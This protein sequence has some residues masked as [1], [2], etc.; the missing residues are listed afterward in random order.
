M[1]NQHM[2]VSIYHW[3]PHSGQNSFDV[4]RKQNQNPNYVVIIVVVVVVVVKD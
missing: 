1:K 2:V 4:A 3:K